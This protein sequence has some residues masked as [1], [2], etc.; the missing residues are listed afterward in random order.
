MGKEADGESD[1]SRRM[2]YRSSP[3]VPVFNFRVD[4][5]GFRILEG[6]YTHLPDS[7]EQRG[8][9]IEGLAWSIT[10]D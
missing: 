10:S 1:E 6:D 7:V 9:N 8:L 5:R 3:S 4:E 2:E